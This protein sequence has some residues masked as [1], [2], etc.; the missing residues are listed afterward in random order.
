MR[1]R[2]K[3]TST[4]LAVAARDQLALV[5]DQTM[6]VGA[7]LLQIDDWI[8]V[9]QA[10]SGQ[11]NALRY[12]GVLEHVTEACDSSANLSSATARAG[13]APFVAVTQQNLVA[14]T[15]DTQQALAAFKVQ[16]RRQ[17]TG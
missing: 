17:V 9:G 14:N 10:M 11:N 1:H 6:I 3:S 4:E 2:P 16:V 13:V 12:I 15:A 8:G 5:A 7:T